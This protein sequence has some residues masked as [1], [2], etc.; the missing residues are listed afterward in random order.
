[1]R[2]TPKGTRLLIYVDPVEEKTS[3]GGVWMP[4][5]HSEI[6]RT[7]TVLAIGRDVKDY[8]VGDRIIVMYLAGTDLHLPAAGILKD[9]YRIIV[10]SN[11]LCLLEDE[12]AE[13]IEGIN[14]PKEK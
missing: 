5:H 13:G 4:E 12:N 2:I 14:E 7:G 10:E 11:I 1:M 6:T 8:R 9:T 3:K